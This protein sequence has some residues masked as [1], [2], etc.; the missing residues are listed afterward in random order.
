MR[1]LLLV[2]PALL[3]A[4]SAEART[5]YYGNKVGM[6]L[7]IVKRSGIGSEQ[8]SILAKHNRQKAGVYCREYGHD[9]SKEC[10]DAEMKSPLH[11][12]ITANCKTGKFTTFYGA[13]MLFQ[14]RNKG[15]EVTTDYL[16][17]SIDDNVVLDGSGASSYDVT[18]DQFK[19]LC[20]N[21]VR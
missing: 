4:T 7:T 21:R 10:I 6:E 5:I 20:P 12:E 2:L 1:R 19:A 11:F 3:L 15:S 17:T 9:F 18:L 13:N 16:I 8:A 14:G